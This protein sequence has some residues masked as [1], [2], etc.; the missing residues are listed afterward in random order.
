MSFF[1]FRIDLGELRDRDRKSFSSH[2]VSELTNLAEPRRGGTH[3]EGVIVRPVVY[4]IPGPRI[5]LDVDTN[6]C[7]LLVHVEEVRAKQKGERFGRMD[8]VLLRHQIHRI[9]LTIR[10]DDVAIVTLEIILLRAQAQVSVDLVLTN[11]V[12]QLVIPVHIQQ[13]DIVLA[14]SVSA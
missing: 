1:T 13:L 2:T 4:A 3:N 11:F 10:R 9:L 5:L 14:V 6:I 12:A 8:T 7:H